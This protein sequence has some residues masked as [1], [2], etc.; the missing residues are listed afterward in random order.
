MLANQTKEEESNKRE[1]FFH[2]RC[3]LQGKVCSLIVDGGTCTNVARTRLAS[4][5]EF[6]TKPHLRPYKLQWLNGNVEMLV[7]KKVEVC[8]KIGK[9][10]DIVLCDVVSMEDSRLLLGRR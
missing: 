6:E 10:E 2:T 1:H 7:N 4:K 3:L 5:L 9:Y 8:F